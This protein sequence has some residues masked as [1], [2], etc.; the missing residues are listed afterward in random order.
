MS[1]MFQAFNKKAKLTEAVSSPKEP[2]V[3]GKRDESTEA[4]HKV[5]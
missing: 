2:K 5:L 3:P 4:K 1:T